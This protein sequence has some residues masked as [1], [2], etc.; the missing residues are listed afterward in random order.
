MPIWA[1]FVR[2]TARLRPPRAIG[3]P[4]SMRPVQLCRESYLQPMEECPRY[5]EYF[6]PGDDVPGGQCP[7]HTG[8]FEQRVERAVEGFFRG[9]GRRIRGIFR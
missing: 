9:L 8:T 4:A 7:L 5:T 2:R 3:P 6:K 1:D